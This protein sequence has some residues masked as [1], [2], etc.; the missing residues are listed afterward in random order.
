MEAVKNEIKKAVIKKDRLNVVYNERYTEAN[1]TNVISKACD[2]IVH[3]DLKEALSRLKLH[4]VVLCEQ[5]EAKLVTKLS[6][7]SPGFMET[8]NNYV[9]SGYSNDSVDGVNGIS[10][11]GAKLL[12]S[13]KIV[14][15]KIFV[16][17]ADEQYPFAEELQIDAAACNAEVEAYLF[18]EKWG[19]KQEQLDFDSDIPE[20]ATTIIEE[21][22]KK[23]GR[24]SNKIETLSD[25][26]ATA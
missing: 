8:I 4:L 14:D 2:Q 9:I 17:M 26:D 16:P 10:I 24:R 23:R 25:L 20:D 22:P 7:S 6:F 11:M 12:Q 19:I 21:K 1:Y 18:E 13:G 3:H 5:P 15:L